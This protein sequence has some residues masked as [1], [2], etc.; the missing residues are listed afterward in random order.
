MKTLLL[1]IVAI[2]TAACT[3]IDSG[4]VG[5]ESTLGN[6]KPD[7]LPPGVYQTFTKTVEEYTLKDVPYSFND[8]T[9]KTKNNITMK[10]VDVDIY[11][12][13]LPAKLPSLY[14][15]YRGDR[16][17]DE[18][19]DYVAANGRVSKEARKGKLDTASLYC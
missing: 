19:K 5:L 9:P 18:N 15:K 12:K 13:T 11:V 2:F 14:T 10:D 1:A 16:F 8:L 17:L 3:Q 7:V 4:S 6:V